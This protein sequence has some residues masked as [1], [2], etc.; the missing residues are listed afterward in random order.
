MLP[1]RSRL[2]GAGGVLAL[3]LATVAIAAAPTEAVD[4]FHT[5]LKKG[6][7]AKI[8]DLLSAE[9]TVY[10]QGFAE[11]SRDDWMTHQL[12]DAMDFAAHTDYRTL[13]RESR[14]VGDLAYV[15]STT[16]T[17]GDFDGHKLELEGA[18]TM[19]LRQDMGEWSIVHVHWSAHE[20]A[21]DAP[22]PKK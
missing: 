21:A 14:Q 19:V 18:E 17:S 15:T 7:A 12:K 13:R 10:E 2:S 20:K 8:K 9:A 6:D 11:T 5:A 16:L 3:C 22:P 1:F 4:A